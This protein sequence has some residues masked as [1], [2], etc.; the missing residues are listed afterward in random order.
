MKLLPTLRALA[1]LVWRL[2]RHTH[3]IVWAFIRPFRF[4]H[5]QVAFM[6]LL[7]TLRA[8]AVLQRHLQAHTH[9]I[10]FLGDSKVVQLASVRR[11]PS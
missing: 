5:E 10:A 9:Q 11:S 8:V 1:V 3:S 6:K 2:Q 7:P 4:I